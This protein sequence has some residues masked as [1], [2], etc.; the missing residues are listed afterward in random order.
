MPFMIRY[1]M[2]EIFTAF[3]TLAIMVTNKYGT[4]KVYVCWGGR[5]SD[6]GCPLSHKHLKSDAVLTV[7]PVN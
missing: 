4:L 7:D 5:H 6:R 3:I 1:E 2:L